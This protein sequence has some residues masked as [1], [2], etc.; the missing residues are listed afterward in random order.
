MPWLLNFNGF[1]EKLI[2]RIKAQLSQGFLLSEHQTLRSPAESANEEQDTSWGSTVTA[3]PGSG[4][5]TSG[6]STEMPRALLPPAF[7]PAASHSP[8]LRPLEIPVKSNPGAQT[9][10]STAECAACTNP[11][12]SGT[13]LASET[14]GEEGGRLMGASSTSPNLLLSDFAP[15]TVFSC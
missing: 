5:Q 12:C 2:C 4:S 15:L 1:R 11:A 13:V 10:C 9:G 14:L 3:G 6:E 7:Y 8:E